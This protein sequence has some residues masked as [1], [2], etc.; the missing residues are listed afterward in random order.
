M[1]GR[2]RGM[3]ELVAF[4]RKL[5]GWKVRLTKKNHHWVTNPQGLS[6][7]IGGTPSDHR[8]IRNTEAALRRLGADIPR[9]GQGAAPKKTKRRATPQ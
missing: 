9:R 4:V 7:Q 6:A 2:D 5:P 1:P 8:S 3:D